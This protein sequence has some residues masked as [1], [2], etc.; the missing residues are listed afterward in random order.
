MMQNSLDSLNAMGSWQTS[1]DK[2][3]GELREQAMNATSSLDA[4]TKRVDLAATRMDSLEAWMTMAPVPA[5]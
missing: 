2:A 4:V 3:F 1:G 5:P